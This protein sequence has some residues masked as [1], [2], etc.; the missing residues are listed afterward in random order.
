MIR[1]IYINFLFFFFGFGVYRFLLH[2][3]Y[4]GRSKFW[5]WAICFDFQKVWGHFD[6][7]LGLM[8]GKKWNLGVGNVMEEM[9][10]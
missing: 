3:I 10:I 8:G 6:R 9:R 2:I 1:V 5:E 7:L 4:I